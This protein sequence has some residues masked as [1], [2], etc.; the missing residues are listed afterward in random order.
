MSNTA[1]KQESFHIDEKS[2]KKVVR[3]DRVP[4]E[5]GSC[6]VDFQGH[7]M[8]VLNI[9]SFGC[10]VLASSTDYQ[11]LKKWFETHPHIDCH[12][13]Y[14]N[15]Q[16]Q[17]L[18]LRWARSEDHIKSVTGEMIVGFEIVGEPLKVDRIQALEVSSEVI[19]EQTRYAHDL[20]QLP[21]EFK[22]F[23]YE[24]KDWLERLKTRIDKLE[25]DSP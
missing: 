13:L 3:Q 11:D 21:A 4:V 6:Y 1:M 19:A 24:M 16:T 14:K 15:I 2:R 25:A 18:S 23:V 8:E 10:A 22:T 5:P 20:A 7:P 12:I 17:S 9:S